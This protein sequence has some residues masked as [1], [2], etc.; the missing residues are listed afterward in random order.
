MN[1]KK[2]CGVSLRFPRKK[3]AVL[4]KLREKNNDNPVE[5]SLL[6]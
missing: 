5:K 3:V 4:A 1:R 2:K 6:E